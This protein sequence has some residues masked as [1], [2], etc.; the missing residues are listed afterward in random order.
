LLWRI[1]VKIYRC[2]VT[3]VELSSFHE[4]MN[5]CSIL[6]IYTNVNKL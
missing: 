1:V 6:N 4:S 2:D 5:M 3:L